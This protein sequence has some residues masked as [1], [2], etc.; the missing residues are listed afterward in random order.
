[1]VFR[2]FVAGSVRR[3]PGTMLRSKARRGHAPRGPAVWL[4]LQSVTP[5]A[6]SGLGG[7]AITAYAVIERRASAPGEPIEEQ[8]MNETR[9]IETTRRISPAVV[10]WMAAS[11]LVVSAAAW[12][13]PPAQASQ[14]V[15]GAI[16]GGG[17]GAMIGQSFGGRDGAVIGGAIGAAAGAAAAQHARHGGYGASVGFGVGYPPPV[18]VP[19]PPVYYSPPPVYYGAPP[20][21][22]APPAVVYRAP[23]VV[24]Q[25]PPRVLYG[26]VH[27]WSNGRHVHHGHRGDRGRGHRH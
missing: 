23:K 10:R 16:I 3:R 20:V 18:Y 9:N 14:P 19:S 27:G 8:K 25:A 4:S 7:P 5:F 12:L 22:V 2:E 26:P 15:V 6:G 17:A 21:I 13:A 24:Y 11:A 1:M